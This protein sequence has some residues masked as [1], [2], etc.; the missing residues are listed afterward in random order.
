MSAVVIGAAGSIG[1][2]CLLALRP[3]HGSVYGLDLISIAEDHQAIRQ[4]DVADYGSVKSALEDIDKTDPIESLIYAAGLNVTGYLN[5][6]DWDEYERLMTVNLRGAFFVGAVM[7]ELLTQR[8]RTFASVFVSSTAGLVGEA[9]GSVYS[10]SKFGVIGF[11]QSFA[12]E[13]AH[14]GGRANAVCPGN[15]DTPMLHALAAKIAR[16]ENSEPAAVLG[17]MAASNAF[18][19]LIETSE[20]AAVCRWLTGPESSGISGQTVVV[21]GPPVQ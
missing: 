3:D 16:R 12:A 5:G 15:V 13:I 2:A 19:R 9:G 6:I 17:Q 4:L 8:T 7:Q 1:H 18:N 11:T 14:V 21:D 10:A 20:V